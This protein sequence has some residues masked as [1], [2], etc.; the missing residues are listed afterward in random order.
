MA[1]LQQGDVPTL[2]LCEMRKRQLNLRLYKRVGQLQLVVVTL[3]TKC[4]NT[5][6]RARSGFFCIAG[7]G[8]LAAAFMWL[9]SA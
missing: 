3:R 6:Q 9:G 8:Q 4:T 2:I 5:H 1:M 7:V